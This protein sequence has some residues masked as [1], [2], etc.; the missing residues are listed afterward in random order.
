MREIRSERERQA[1]MA[2]IKNQA[3]SLPEPDDQGRIDIG[4]A[5]AWARGQGSQSAS[6]RQVK[7]CMDR[8]VF[9]SV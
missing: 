1:A 5:G 4:P 3:Q 6:G 7:D 9:R 2:I 8:P